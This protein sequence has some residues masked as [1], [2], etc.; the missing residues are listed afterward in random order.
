MLPQ[1]KTFEVILYKRVNYFS[2]LNTKLNKH[3]G[4]HNGGRA[5]GFLDQF[6]SP[7][8]ILAVGAKIGQARNGFFVYS[9][10]RKKERKK[11]LAMNKEMRQN[12][13][14]KIMVSGMAQS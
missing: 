7:T 14:Q 13:T 2:K 12:T 3:W 9:P 10:G 8:F 4:C 5:V 11:S 1:N 6:E